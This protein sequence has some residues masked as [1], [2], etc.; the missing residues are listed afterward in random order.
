M[1]PLWWFAILAF[2]AFAVLMVF[3]F[4]AYLPVGIGN[5]IRKFVHALSRAC[6]D[7]ENDTLEGAPSRRVHRLSAPPNSPPVSP[8]YAQ[9]FVGQ[10][11]DALRSQPQPNP[12]RDLFLHDY[13]GVEFKRRTRMLHIHVNHTAYDATTGKLTVPVQQKNVESF[14]L[15]VASVPKTE[16][17]ISADNKTFTVAHVD[18]TNP[19]FDGTATVVEGIY[20]AITLAPALQTAINAELTGT[21]VSVVYSSL[22][23]SYTFATTATS[24]SLDFRNYGV[25]GTMLG[26]VAADSPTTAAASVASSNRVDLTRGRFLELS[27]T[28]MNAYYGNSDVVATVDLTSEINA[29]RDLTCVRT[30]VQPVAMHNLVLDL[31]VQEADGSYSIYNNRGL[32]FQMTFL[33]RV[34]VDCINTEKLPLTS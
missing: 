10:L 25:L 21:P 16:F 13:S 29:H 11:A 14:E 24:V 30:F 12:G 32:A 8:F 20:T 27:G 22:T 23:E 7:D 34:V 28:G 15:Y 33:A 2:V 1:K 5:P 4:K 3:H 26:F 18:P 9:Q 31:R 6:G 17:V 19:D